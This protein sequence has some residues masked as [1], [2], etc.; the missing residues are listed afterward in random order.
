MESPPY[1]AVI[2]CKPVALGVYVT[3]QLPL[4]SEQSPALKLPYSPP[5]LHVIVPV[6]VLDVPGLVSVTV[7]VQV[8]E[9]PKL[10]EL[11]VQETPVV[12]SRLLIV[13]VCVA[14][15]KEAVAVIVALLGTLS[16]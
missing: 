12:V 10:T 7:A 14:L 13:S 9:S 1:E 6:G 2:I 16:L 4:L 11:G 3:K 5:L 15:A 8:V